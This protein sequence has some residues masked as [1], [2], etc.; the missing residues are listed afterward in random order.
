MIL[1]HFYFNF[2]CFSCNFA[3]SPNFH[4]RHRDEQGLCRY[5][6][7][8]Y[9]P[10]IRADIIRFSGNRPII[11]Q[12]GLLSRHHL[13]MPMETYCDSLY[14]GNSVCVACGNGMPIY[15]THFTLRCNPNMMWKIQL[16]SSGL[17]LICKKV[18]LC[19]RN[20]HTFD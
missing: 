18:N 13:L 2:M 10:K 16:C 17:C 20:G 19:H 9:L 1:C 11:K 14:L 8:G 4:Y 5:S 12:K 6:E 15:Q 3:K 7:F